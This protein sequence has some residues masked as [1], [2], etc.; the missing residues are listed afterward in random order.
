MPWKIKSAVGERLRLVKLVF[1]AQQS[2]AQLCRVFGVSR[3]TAYKWMKR[4]GTG[5]H[6]A[7]SNASRRPHRSPN[8]TRRR[9]IKAIRRIRRRHRHWGPKKIQAVLSQKGG[10]PGRPAVRTIARYLK[11]WGWVHRR[12]RRSPKGPRVEL[13]AL[14]LPQGPNEVWTVDFKG[15]FRTGDGKRAEPLTVRDLFSRY[16]LAVRLVPDQSWNH[17]RVLFVELLVDMVGRGSFA[18]TMVGRSL[19]RVQGG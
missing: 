17:V 2:I 5:G 9:W 16:G 19:P 1:R 13:A 8:K 6:R 10:G 7:L 3:P 11:A 12:A 14:T 4:F 18:W 15:W